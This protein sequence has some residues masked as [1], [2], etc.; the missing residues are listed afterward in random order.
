M[1][2]EI[3]LTDLKDS[4]VRRMLREAIAKEKDRS[5]PMHKRGEKKQ[6]EVDDASEEMEEESE[7]LAELAAEKGEPKEIPMTGEDV[8]EETSEKLAA[9]KKNAKKLGKPYSPA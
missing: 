3:D 1:E 5:L 8:S 9:Q 4:A 6:I 7:K 2:W